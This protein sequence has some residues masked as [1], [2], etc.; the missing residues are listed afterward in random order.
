[1][2]DSEAR[3]EGQ[4]KTFPL[5]AKPGSYL[6]LMDAEVDFPRAL[7]EPKLKFARHREIIIAGH[8][9][10]NTRRF[11]RSLFAHSQPSGDFTRSSFRRLERR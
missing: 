3:R 11:F 7:H 5:V 1:M 6:P 2:D 10:E 4:V 8:R 9:Y